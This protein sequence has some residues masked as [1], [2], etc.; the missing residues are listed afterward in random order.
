M[1]LLEDRYVEIFELTKSYP[2]PDGETVNVVEGFNLIIRQREVVG[3]IG[4]SGCG[5]S[6]VLTMVAGLT[7]I[8]SG[9]IAVAG[10][11]IDGPG[12]DRAV[13]FQSPCL[14][15][16]L[17]ALQNVQL[18]VDQVYPHATRRQRQQVCEYYLSLVGLGDA[19]H[20]HPRELSGG[21]QQRVGIA[22]A[23]A[24][25]PKMLLLDEPFGRLDSLTRMELQEVILEILNREQITTLVITHDVDEAIYMSDRICMMTSGPRARVGQVLDVPFARPR[26]RAEVLDHPLYYDL[27]GSL[28][29]FL[30]EQDHAGLPAPETGPMASVA[31][32]VCDAAAPASPN[33]VRKLPI[34]VAAQA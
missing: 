30:E 16:W 26:H 7:A 34:A 29:R 1:A 10:R 6:T 18:G 12:P 20:K 21:M 13:V 28:V 24:L 4:H 5:K 33:P 9:G 32:L 2:N 31:A 3:V 25:K 19:L 17:T 27:R 22:R 15:P 11:E 8:S 14:L 23:I